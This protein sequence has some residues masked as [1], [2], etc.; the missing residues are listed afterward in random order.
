M[1]LH[2][3]IS[4]LPA[5]DSLLYMF[6][7]GQNTK[8]VEEAALEAEMKLVLETC[9]LSSLRGSMNFAQNKTIGT[10]CEK[11]ASIRVNYKSDIYY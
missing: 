7:G 11:C 6:Y 3:V 2:S 10:C 8:P 1:I 5:W 4:P 9:D